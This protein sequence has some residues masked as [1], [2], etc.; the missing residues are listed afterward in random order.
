[1]KLR[2]ISACLAASALLAA[3]CQKAA[4]VATE[5]AIER[6]TGQRVEVDRDGNQVRLRSEEGEITVA[7]GEGVALP[8]DFPDDVFLP[9]NFRVSSVM[10][11]GNARLVNLEAEGQVTTM[12]DAA[13][14]DMESKGW[15]QT[16]AMQQAD[17]AMLGFSKDDREVA[18]TFSHHNGE[19]LM[20]GIQIRG[21][22]R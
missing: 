19:G 16:L 1:M 14:A 4:D 17:G 21:S 11:V 20:V 2:L 22:R 5:K 8:V 15:T 3:G 6:A 9:A 18:Y 12:F 13:R 10:D 7:S